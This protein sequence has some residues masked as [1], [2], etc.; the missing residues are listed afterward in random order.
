V[1]TMPADT[2]PGIAAG[3]FAARALP[4]GGASPLRGYAAAAHARSYRA[5][6]P[7]SLALSVVAGTRASG[8]AARAPA[9]V[10]IFQSPLRCRRCATR[11]AGGHVR[12]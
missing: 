6:M 9:H 3:C 12:V 5:A 11:G 4:R 7:C 1:T 8:V 2:K 10:S